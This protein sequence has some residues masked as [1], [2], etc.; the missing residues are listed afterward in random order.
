[1]KATGYLTVK[2][3]WSRYSDH[4]GNRILERLVIEK[5][6]SSKPK[7]GT[8]GAAVIKLSVDV[9]E[10][11]FKPFEVDADIEVRAE[12]VGTVQVVVEPFE[13]GDES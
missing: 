9:P 4:K 6:T 8:F 5:V 1:M 13:D 7:S 11:V 3:V 2:P 12:Q 10:H